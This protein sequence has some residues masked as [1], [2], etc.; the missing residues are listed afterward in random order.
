MNMDVRDVG[1]T[2]TSVPV[3]DGFTMPARFDKHD[4]TLMTWPP[5]EEAVG[6]DVEGF[7]DEVEFIAKAISEFEPVTLVVDPKDEADA[8]AR[9]G[10]FAELLVLPVDA[11][12]IRDNG[13]IFV[14]N[15]QGEVAGVHF[16][17]N[18][19]G[20]RVQCPDTKAMPSTVVSRFGMRCYRA[21]FICE[22]GGISVDGEG[23]LITTEQVMRNANRYASLSREQLEQRLHEFLGIEK[24]IWLGLGLVE[25]TE[26]DGHVDNV[27]EYVSP[28]VVL[29][30]TV[31]DR[32]NPNYELLKDNLKCLKSERDAKGRQ[33]DIIEMDALPYLEPMNGKTLVAPYVNAY[34]VNGAVIAPEA[35]SALDDKGYRILEQ[36]FPGRKIVPAPGRF[37][38]DGGGGIGCITQ[39]IPA[40]TAAK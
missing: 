32:A 10:G 19:W 2:C 3:A 15:E 40:G 22:G 27:V 5:R 34:V 9:C 7:R 16:D 13:P 14:R 38:A 33:L 23:T 36:A 17:F 39:Q 35:N 1:Q 21:P 30:Q 26:T 28:G 8:R 24:V 12:W 11:C 29:A 31:S 20:G 18:G 25:D 4:R 37:Q 6:A